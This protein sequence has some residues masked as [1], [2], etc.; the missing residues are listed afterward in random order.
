MTDELVRG[1][2]I[3]GAVAFMGAR[4]S[5][6][7]TERLLSGLSKEVR[8]TLTQV[9]PIQ[10]YPRSHHIELMNAIASVQKSEQGVYEDLVAYGQHVGAELASGPLRPF[11]LVVTLKLF[12][13]KLPMLWV[14]D[15]QDDGKLESDIAQLDEARLPLR[16]SGIQGYDHIGVA[17][18][19]WI[20]GA[21][22]R[23][24]RKGLQLKQSGW[25]LRL[26]GPAEMACEVSWS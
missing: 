3:S 6:E 10:W 2:W 21:M 20:K 16:L 15:H 11:M 22:T 4:Y 14:R 19:G 12:A 24:N 9:D 25:S 13:K 26:R 1:Y 18:L 17:T 23:F 5:S 7:T 8:V